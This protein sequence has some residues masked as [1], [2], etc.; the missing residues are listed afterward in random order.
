MSHTQTTA[1]LPDHHKF[2]EMNALAILR[3]CGGDVF[4]AQSALPCIS[5]C[6]GAASAPPP[7]LDALCK[8]VISLKQSGACTPLA[9]R[10]SPTGVKS[11]ACLPPNTST[12][13]AQQ[14]YVLSTAWKL[15]HKPTALLSS[16]PAARL[17]AKAPWTDD[18][19][20]VSNSVKCP[21]YFAFRQDLPMCAD[22]PV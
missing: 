12:A 15:Q 8:S 7:S 19:V 6:L 2:N 1:A 16:L 10:L 18:E 11:K 22:T 4:A 5:S 17:D 13:T 3:G 14:L 20:P 9:P 21:E